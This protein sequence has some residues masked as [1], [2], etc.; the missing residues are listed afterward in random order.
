[1]RTHELVW[2]LGLLD[3]VADVEA[4]ALR[5]DTFYLTDPWV[6][7][8]EVYVHADS[9]TDAGRLVEELRLR[10]DV[11]AS[12]LHSYEDGTVKQ[13]RTWRAWSADASQTAP[14]NVQV[15]AAEVVA[16]ETPEG[17]AA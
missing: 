7:C 9:W 5:V 2:A 6:E 14:V 1:M 15:T 4:L 17:L 13:F 3:S 10:E 8:I 12:R 16:D 11:D